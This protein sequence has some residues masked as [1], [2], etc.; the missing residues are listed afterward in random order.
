MISSENQIETALKKI[1]NFIISDDKKPL[2]VIEILAY[3]LIIIGF[4]IPNYPY[5]K[6]EA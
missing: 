4:F 6:Y 3:F 2:L 5:K 1:E